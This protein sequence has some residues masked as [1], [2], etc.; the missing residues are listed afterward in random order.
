MKLKGL[1]KLLISVITTNH[2]KW[3]PPPP[4]K[5]PHPPKPPLPKSPPINDILSETVPP[6]TA[7]ALPAAAT[8][9]DQSKRKKFKQFKGP[10]KVSCRF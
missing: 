4:A 6:G 5:V 8:P 3:K 2:S 9:S 1:S 10:K 7:T